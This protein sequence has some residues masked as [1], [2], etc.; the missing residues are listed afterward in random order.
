MFGTGGVSAEG[1]LFLGRLTGHFAVVSTC[2]CS[3]GKNDDEV[4]ILVDGFEK[5]SNLSHSAC[6]RLDFAPTRAPKVVLTI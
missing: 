5:Q 3:F 2:P 1:F 6:A 4:F